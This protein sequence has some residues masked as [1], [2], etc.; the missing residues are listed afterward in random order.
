MNWGRLSA[1][2]YRGA[3]VP[4]ALGIWLAAA[5]VL[6]AVAIHATPGSK[7]GAAGWGV[8]AGSILVFIAG[9]IDDLVPVGPRGLREHLR[10][11]A[12]GHMTTGILKLL[13]S[14]GCSLVIVALQPDRPLPVQLAGALLM[15]ASANLWNA[16]DVQPGRAIKLFLL[17]GVFLL[18]VDWRLAPTVPGAWG[19]SVLAL[20][21][22][23]RERAML[24]DGGSN[25]LGI[26]AGVGLYVGLP[27][28]GVVAAAAAAV[29]L[30][31]AAETVT[32]SRLIDATPPLRW[33]DRLGRWRPT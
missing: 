8:L 11:L 28:W 20:G 14:G 17:V 3:R 33:I 32:L 24:G 10:S 6:S 9:L 22:D 21:F 4:R 2:N 16:L 25:L 26:T 30:N 13:I 1:A 19:A 31:L 15:A 18:P 29:A 5:A 23:L 7:V 27:A 12:A